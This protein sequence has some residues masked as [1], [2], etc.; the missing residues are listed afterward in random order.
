MV[1]KTSRKI[2]AA[3]IL[4]VAGYLGGWNGFSGEINMNLQVLYVPLVSL[5]AIS[6]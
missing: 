2:V 5:S 6:L 3:V 4:Q 1:R